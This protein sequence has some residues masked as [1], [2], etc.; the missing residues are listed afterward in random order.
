MKF[1]S[2]FFVTSAVRVFA[3]MI[4]VGVAAWMLLGLSP[5]S[6][7]ER[8]ARA[9]GVLPADDSAI[10]GPLRA[11][12]IAR[13]G[14]AHDLERSVPHQLTALAADL[15]QFDLGRSWRTGES[16]TRVVFGAAAKTFALSA[17]AL[18]LAFACGLGLAGLS[19]RR[20]TGR[21]WSSSLASL[22]ISVMLVTPPVWIA[23]VGLSFSRDG[24]PNISVAVLALATIPTA[25][26]ARHLTALWDGQSVTPWVRALRA[27]GLAEH[28]IVLRHGLRVGGPRLVALA[29]SL[30]G[31]CLGAAMVIE[32][33]F[34]VRGLGAMLTDASQLGDAPVVSAV[35]AVSALAISLASVFASAVARLCDPRIGGSESGVRS[36]LR[37]RL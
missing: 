31:Y 18:M 33:V 11:D 21:S 24:D 9:K 27:R 10:S 22:A 17:A 19:R 37:A 35:L 16:N 36:T 12:L 13:V 6:A 20:Q 14:R 30:V 26:V 1:W 29:P 8:A 4:L 15:A 3:T 25:I 7:A 2:F 32:T 23:L 5:G 34:G 28:T